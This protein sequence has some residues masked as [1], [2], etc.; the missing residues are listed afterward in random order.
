[1]MMVLAGVTWKLCGPMHEMRG[2]M[3]WMEEQMHDGLGLYW[4]ISRIMG[5]WVG[6]YGLI[7]MDG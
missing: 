7:Q 3:V 5:I 2:G 4:F 6:W 1:M